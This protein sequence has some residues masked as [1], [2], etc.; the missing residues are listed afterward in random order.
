MPKNGVAKIAAKKTQ[1]LAKPASCKDSPFA[2][3]KYSIA[4]VLRKGKNTD[5][6]STCNARMYQ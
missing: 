3:W 5:A 6:Y 2:S 4:K 1:L